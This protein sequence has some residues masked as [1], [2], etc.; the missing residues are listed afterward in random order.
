MSQLK[1]VT[2]E[3][4]QLKK[5]SAYM[6]KQ[7]VVMATDIQHWQNKCAT[8]NAEVGALFQQL[9]Q[10]VA[11]SAAFNPAILEAIDTRAVPVQQVASERLPST[12][13]VFAF[14][15]CMTPPAAGSQNPTMEALIQALPQARVLSE[16]MEALRTSGAAPKPDPPPPPAALSS[17]P[18]SAAALTLPSSSPLSAMN[19]AALR[20][21]SVALKEPA[22][23]LP[24]LLLICLA[25]CS[26]IAAAAGTEKPAPRQPA[27]KL[28]Q[29][30]P[31]RP[32]S[33]PAPTG[34]ATTAHLL[35][36][37]RDAAN[38][39]QEEG[40]A[41]STSQQP[42]YSGSLPSLDVEAILAAARSLTNGQ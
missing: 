24:C 39:K 20:C 41:G 36:K 23:H 21:L 3:N 30:K 1:R 4:E 37:L 18:A 10:V 29:P 13:R 15:C 16:A 6:Q 2:Q 32:A 40:P 7:H 27:A 42:R 8:A 12:S 35:S 26:Q 33:T 9:Q 19:L 31:L 28:V 38:S 22:Y 17:V 25:L 5:Y 14:H 11:L 34:S